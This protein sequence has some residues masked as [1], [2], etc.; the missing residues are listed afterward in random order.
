MLQSMGSLESDTTQCISKLDIIQENW[1]H[2]G[3]MNCTT[4][5]IGCI[6][7]SFLSPPELKHHVVKET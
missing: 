6:F 4:P 5:V 7:V 2:E 1:F 3:E